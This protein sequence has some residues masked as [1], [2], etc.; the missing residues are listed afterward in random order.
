MAGLRRQELVLNHFSYGLNMMEPCLT[1]TPF[2][3]PPHYGHFILD[4]TKAQSVIFVHKQ[5]N[6]HGHPIGP[7][8]SDGDQINW[9]LLYLL[10]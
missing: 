2:I 8:E 4:L 3:W 7:D 9:V 5:P 10:D 1:T 6:Q